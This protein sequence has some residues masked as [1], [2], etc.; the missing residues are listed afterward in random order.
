MADGQYQAE[1]RERVERKTQHVHHGKGADQRHRHRRQRDD[2][3]PPGLQEQHHHQ[4]HQHH[5]LKQGMDHGFD[6][7]AHKNGRVVDDRVIHALWEL[8]L[9]LR[10]AFTHGVRNL[11][12][13]GARALKNRNSDGGLI[14]Q[15]RAQGVLAGT[16]F[17]PCDVFKAG[18]L[19][20]IART[21]D[22]VLELLLSHQPALG[23]D[24]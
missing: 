3:G 19:A 5:G 1:Q 16:E 7:T 21:N 13:I 12:G 18:N 6:G 17:N 14:V 8:L 11:D 20:V 15:Q 2:R 22:D 9:Q 4:H 24:R 23:I 10:H